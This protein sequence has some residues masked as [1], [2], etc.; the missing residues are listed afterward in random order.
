MHI[1]PGR[2]LCQ[3]CAFKQPQTYGTWRNNQQPCTNKS[4]IADAE[5]FRFNAWTYF[6]FGVASALFGIYFFGRLSFHPHNR[7]VFQSAC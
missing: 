4:K 2:N 5:L 6:F 1:D 7:R 3:I